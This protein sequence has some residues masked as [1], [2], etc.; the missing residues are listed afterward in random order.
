MKYIIIFTTTFILA[1][2]LHLEPC[3]EKGYYE[4]IS[5]IKFPRYYQVLETFDNGEWLTGTVFKIKKS[6]LRNFII[7]NN[8]DTL[9]K[10]NDLHLQSN[11]Y[12]INNKADFKTIKNIYYTSKSREKNN[13]IYVEDLNSNVLWAEISYPDWGGH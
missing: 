13:W 1:S 4:K 6:V 2:C 10:F 12:L 3:F 9:Q 7:E 11:N 8:F 5:G